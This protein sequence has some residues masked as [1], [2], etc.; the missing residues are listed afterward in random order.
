MW[1]A[2]YRAIPLEALEI[3]GRNFLNE[4]KPFRPFSTEQINYAD[5][6]RLVNAQESG[7]AWCLIGRNRA[8]TLLHYI[9]TG[10]SACRTSTKCC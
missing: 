7:Q 4:A 9:S 1:L 6:C 2:A 5:A 3:R 10:E 8:S